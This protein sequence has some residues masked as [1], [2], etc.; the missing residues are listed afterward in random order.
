MSIVILQSQT[1]IEYFSRDFFKSM[2][3]KNKTFKVLQLYNSLLLTFNFFYPKLHNRIISFG[4]SCEN[5]TPLK[6]SIRKT[7]MLWQ[8]EKSIYL[9]RS[10]F[11]CMG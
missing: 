10:S 6:R 5:K 3:Y 11:S 2:Y 4:I 7:Q 9:K 8:K 1:N